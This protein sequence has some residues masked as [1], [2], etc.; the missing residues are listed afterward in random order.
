MGVSRTRR[1]HSIE[2]AQRQLRTPT[3]GSARLSLHA[4]VLHWRLLASAVALSLAVG[5]VYT[6][7]RGTHYT[8]T[9]VLSLPRET[10]ASQL[11]QTYTALAKSLKVAE[12]VFEREEIEQEMRRETRF[13][14]DEQR[15]VY[16]VEP[17][18]LEAYLEKVDGR[19][20]PGTEL[21]VLT[22]S[23][24][25][26]EIAEE[27]ARAHAEALREELRR[28]LSTNL[29]ER[30]DV[31]KKHL[32]GQLP[33]G[34][35]RETLQ[36]QITALESELARS[37]ALPLAIVQPATPAEKKAPSL[38]IIGAVSL[39]IGLLGGIA[40]ALGLDR[41]RGTL[42]TPID[43]GAAL[44][45]P[46][47][48]YIPSFGEPEKEELQPGSRAKLLNRKFLEPRE[49]RKTIPKGNE[50]VTFHAPRSAASE[51]FRT[52]RAGILLAGEDTSS[53]VIVVTSARKGEGKTTVATNLAVALAHSSAP[54]LLIDADVR[55]PKVA[56]RFGLFERREGLSDYLSGA[57]DIDQLVVSS[58]IPN[59]YI[60]TAGSSVTPNGVELITSRKMAELLRF[61]GKRFAHVIIDTPPVMAVG[62]GLVLSRLAG[63]VVLVVRSDDTPRRLAEE[64][65]ERLKQVN[66]TILGVVVN[67]LDIY[68]KGSAG[69]QYGVE[70]DYYTERLAVN[71]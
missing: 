11:P 38:L 24:K 63:G 2:K 48:G 4:I 64:A 31:L 44:N 29:K 12:R 27:A 22:V 14:G 30:S 70:A 26:P 39:V 42:K 15:G 67:D 33:E 57:I 17:S 16:A 36:E 6:L 50:L 66:A 53:D 3:L 55:Q 28:E 21:L 32:Q 52:L 62:D 7:I 9:V 35:S 46:P 56:Q 54:T 10:E 47:L 69:Y 8:S 49:K 61:L 25:T 68:T 5:S 71:R 34:V 51:A 1:S 45:L 20:L 59:L 41:W 60:A 23:M 19:L 65:A 37:Y 58:G 40:A 43:A 18:L 13:S